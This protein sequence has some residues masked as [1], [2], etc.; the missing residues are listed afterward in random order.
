MDEEF[1]QAKAEVYLS[2]YKRKGYLYYAELCDYLCHKECLD[3]KRK[4]K[5]CG[6]INPVAIKNCVKCGWYIGR[7]NVIPGYEFTEAAERENERT[8][9]FS[10][11]GILDEDFRMRKTKPIPEDKQIQM[12]VSNNAPRGLTIRYKPI[13][14]TTS[15]D[16][17]EINR[18]IAEQNKMFMADQQY[19]RFL[20]NLLWMI[21]AYFGSYILNGSWMIRV[22]LIVYFIYGCMRMVVAE[23]RWK[24]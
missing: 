14:T 9:S 2:I 24:I 11:N 12:P 15:T 3:D 4:C 8:T 1:R 5:H 6:T 20:D 17:A 19:M 18:V 13:P 22:A 23:E 21:P 7:E 10:V 16:R